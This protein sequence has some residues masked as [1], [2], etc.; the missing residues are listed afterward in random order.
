MEKFSCVNW[1]TYAYMLFI[2]SVFSSISLSHTLLFTANP[3]R[4][5]LFLKHKR[6]LSLSSCGFTRLTVAIKKTVTETG[7]CILF[8]IAIFGKHMHELQQELKKEKVMI[9]EYC[10]LSSTRLKES[11]L[12]RIT[13]SLFFFRWKPYTGYRLLAK[14]CS[15]Y[16]TYCSHFSSLNFLLE[17]QEFLRSPFPCVCNKWSQITS[18]SSICA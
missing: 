17:R 15:L 16:N 13:K 10:R 5:L 9:S 3:Y 1:V 18:K 12:L 14:F 11:Y 4:W 8:A 6:I 2:K 7:L